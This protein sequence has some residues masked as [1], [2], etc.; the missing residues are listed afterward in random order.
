MNPTYQHFTNLADANAYIA[1]QTALMALPPDGVTQVW[2]VPITLADGTYV[3]LAYN[4]ATA[5]VWD[6]SWMLPTPTPAL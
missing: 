2:T 5:V 6:P 3:V 4:D 1:A